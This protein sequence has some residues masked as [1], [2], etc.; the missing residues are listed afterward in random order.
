MR[1]ARLLSTTA[2]SIYEFML[3]G[4]NLV[5]CIIATLGLTLFV[6]LVSILGAGGFFFIVGLYIVTRF[7]YYRFVVVGTYGAVFVCVIS[8]LGAGGFFF[9]VGLYIVTR[10]SYYRFVV[11]GT[12]GAVFVCVISVLGA[13]GSFCFCGF[14]GMSQLC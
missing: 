11:V 12:C 9:I 6:S 5:G 2:E 14:K 4:N 3:S 13:G 7:S 10:F 8:V 1:F